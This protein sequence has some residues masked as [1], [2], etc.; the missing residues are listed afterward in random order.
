MA[1]F[2]GPAFDELRRRRRLPAPGRQTA[3]EAFG[4]PVFC[5]LCAGVPGPEIDAA[6]CTAED[7]R[8]FWTGYTFVGAACAF[9]LLIEL[10]SL[11]GPR[12]HA[13]TETAAPAAAAA[14]NSRR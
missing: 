3:P 8:Q 11:P 13:P 12:A 6:L 10:A 2:D 1:F 5:G 4:A 7:I 14:V 9:F